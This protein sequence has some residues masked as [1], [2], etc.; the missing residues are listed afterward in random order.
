MS[1]SNA[2]Q[3]IQVAATTMHEWELTL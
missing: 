3:D 2:L 1:A